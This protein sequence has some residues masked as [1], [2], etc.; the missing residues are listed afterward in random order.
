MTPPYLASSNGCKSHSTGSTSRVPICVKDK[1]GFLKAA[2]NL[3]LD[4]C[5]DCQRRVEQVEYDEKRKVHVVTMKSL[6]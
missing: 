4:V 2:A 3:S 6:T 5:T 1:F